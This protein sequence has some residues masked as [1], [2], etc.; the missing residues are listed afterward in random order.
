M[1]KANARRIVSDD[2]GAAAIEYALVA[3]LIGVG[4]VGM[5]LALGE[6]VENQYETVGTEYAVAANGK[7]PD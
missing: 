3:M 5:M 1:R 4:L 6:E 2:T 7:A